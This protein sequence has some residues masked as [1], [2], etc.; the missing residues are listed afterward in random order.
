MQF[1]DEEAAQSIVDEA[2][3][4][5]AIENVFAGMAKG[6]ARNF[7]VVR[8]AIGH[9]DALY[10]FKSGIDKTSMT[11]GVKAGGYWPHNTDQGLTNHQSTVILFDPDTGQP[12]AVVSGNHLTALRT[13]AA[14]AV[15]VHYLARQDAKTLAIVGAGH[16][17]QFQLRAV[18]EQRDF[19]RV[20]AWNISTHGLDRLEEVTEELGLDFASVSR[21]ELGQV[22]DVI[23]TITPSTEALLDVA[24]IRPGTHL[25]CMGA[26][27]IG[28]Q[29]VD[30]RILEKARVYTDE[31]AQS[32]L[33]GEGQHAVQAGVLSEADITPLGK[34]ITGD[35]PGRTS[36]DEI[37]VFDGTGVGLQD[38][39]VARRV[40]DLAG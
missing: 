27:T 12:T 14:C 32:A 3:A 35:D 11:L 19:E 21:D 37:T 18:A 22:S 17:A 4:F 33:L 29:E 20:V 16:Q 38:L 28:K 1:F 39:A 15:A 6:E 26:D 13:G 25:S 10:G 9:A 23:I 30:Y 5:D 40:V 7:P 34:V 8:E 36:D 31:P 24:Q 2:V